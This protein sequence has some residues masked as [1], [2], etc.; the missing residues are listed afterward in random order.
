MSLYDLIKKEFSEELLDRFLRYVAI[1][2]TSD[3]AISQDKIPSTKGQWTLLR[4]LES[5]LLEMGFND[6]TLDSS[7]YLIARIPGNSANSEGE[8]I[9]FMAHVDTNDDVPGADI[10][11][12]VHRAYDGGAINLADGIVLSPAN[13][14]LLEHYKAETIITS[15]GR[16]LLGADDKAGVAE[17]MTALSWIRRNSSWP[18][19]PL[20]IIFTPDEET[21][22]GMSC[23]PREELESS[24]CFVVDGGEEGEMGIE[25][26]HAWLAEISFKGDS[27]HPGS[28]RG[29]LVNAVSMAAMFIN[30]L[31]GNESPEATDGRY[32]N[33]W[34]H[35]LRGRIDS[36]ELI[37]KYRSFDSKDIERRSN[38]LR[39]FA[40]AVEAASPGG[41]IT[42]RLKEE[43]RNMREVFDRNPDIVA[44]LR[45]AVLE[46]GIQPVERSIRGGTDGSILT[47]MGIPTPNIFAGGINFHSRQEWVALPAMVRAT[48]VILN[49][50]Y[51][52]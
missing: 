34:A 44:R 17:I 24:C 39:A 22:N 13:S 29:R 46:S 28:G 1:D 33:Y 5:E 41:R 48:T 3:P 43:Y 4:L 21:G 30:M 35:D 19:R 52:K 15:G 10:R 27:I 18:H 47:A 45:K 23:F 6:V 8:T 32:G 25:C 37:I 42:V 11:P 51:N 16:T 31:P 36:A 7:G 40:Q 14:P 12:L 26:F 50:M 2:T 20:E 9:G 49:L 38:A